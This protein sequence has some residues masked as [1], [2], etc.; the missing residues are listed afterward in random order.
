MRTIIAASLLFLFW[1]MLSGHTEVLLIA[2]GLL[3]TLLVVFLSSR[4]K[5]IDH[6]SYPLHLSLK[7]LPYFAYLGKEILLANLDV[8][9]RIIKP[10]RSI[11]PAIEQ[12]PVSKE[13]DLGKVIYANSITLTPGTVTVEMTDEQLKIH[14]LNKDAL[15]DLE[16]GVMADKVPDKEDITS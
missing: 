14:A 13:T 16:K 11:N 5:I 9:K 1:F 12:L 10:G 4:M 3:S 6:E 15:T 8:I 2:L 7:L